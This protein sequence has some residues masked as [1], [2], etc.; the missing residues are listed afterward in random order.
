MVLS[1]MMTNE[2]YLYILRNYSILQLENVL[3][4][5][6]NHAYRKGRNGFTKLLKKC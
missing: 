1:L 6:K 3:K 2:G 5:I 4:I